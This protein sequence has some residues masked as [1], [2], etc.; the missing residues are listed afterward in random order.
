MGKWWVRTYIRTCVCTIHMIV[1]IMRIWYA[2]SW[3]SCV[4]TIR[5]IVCIV[6]IW[7]ARSCVLCLLEYARAYLT[8]A[9]SYVRIYASAYA[10]YARLCVSTIRT[11]VHIKYA[12]SCVSNTHDRVYQKFQLLKNGDFFLVL[13]KLLFYQK[14]QIH[15][16][17]QIKKYHPIST[18]D[19]WN[20]KKFP[21]PARKV[22]IQTKKK[23]QTGQL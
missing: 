15:T 14:T 13:I 20:P 4:R 11:I 10:G 22:R 23:P 7:Y 2:W 8:Y 18:P 19:N 3:V 6:R 12:S 9:R 5:R 16:L 21:P 17:P 1:R